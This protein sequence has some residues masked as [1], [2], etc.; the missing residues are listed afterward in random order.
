MDKFKRN[1]T[2]GK[3]YKI[4]RFSKAYAE[5]KGHSRYYVALFNKDALTAF[6]GWY[7]DKLRH[8]IGDGE[9]FICNID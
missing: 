1:K 9:N 8:A 5:A 6:D 2:T 7:T 3:G 4:T